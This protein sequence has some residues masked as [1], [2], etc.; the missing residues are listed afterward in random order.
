MSVTITPTFTSVLDIS[1]IRTYNFEL[2]TLLTYLG[3]N[4]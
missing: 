1:C 4:N 2:G 3:G